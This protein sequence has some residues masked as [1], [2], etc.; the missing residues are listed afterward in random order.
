MDCLHFN[1]IET[2][3]YK[4]IYNSLEVISSGIKLVLE[5]NSIEYL[6]CQKDTDFL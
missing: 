6:K 4:L 1:L 3:F 5:K 2:I